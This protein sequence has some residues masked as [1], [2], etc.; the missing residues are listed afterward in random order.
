MSDR[1]SFAFS[2]SVIPTPRELRR[3][4]CWSYELAY[5][6]YGIFLCAIS[7]SFYA[8]IVQAMAMNVYFQIAEC[9]LSFAKVHKIFLVCMKNHKS[10]GCCHIISAN[11]I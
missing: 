9:S 11:K 8:K 10:L 2:T 6:V 1:Y 7:K 3:W 5:L 4:I